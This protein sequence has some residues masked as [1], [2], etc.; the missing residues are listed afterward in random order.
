MEDKRLVSEQDIRDLLIEAVKK[1]KLEAMQL[2]IKIH[3]D[4]YSRGTFRVAMHNA[5][6]ALDKRIE[7]A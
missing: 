4:S 6:A 2:A 7:K 3:A 1:A 5:M